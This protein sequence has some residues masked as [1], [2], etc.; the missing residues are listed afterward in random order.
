MSAQLIA[1]NLYRVILLT[2]MTL[3]IIMLVHNLVLYRQKL[4]SRFSMMLL[5]GTSVCVFE[6]LWDTFSFYPEL[7]PLI[8]ICTGAYTMSFLNFVGLFNR[9]FLDRFGISV[10]KKWVTWLIYDLPNAIMLILCITTPWT[11][12]F[13]YVDP[14]GTVQYMPLSTLYYVLLWTYNLTALGLAVHYMLSKKK[15]DASLAKTARSL[16]IFGC[17]LTVFDLI[18]IWILGGTYSDYLVSSLAVSV[19][20]VYLTANINVNALMESRSQFEAV[21]A[22]LR[23]AATIQSEALP[24]PAPE[25]PDHPEINL[26]CSMDTAKEVG[27]DFYDYFSIDADHICFL[28]ADV[29]GKGTAAALFMMKAKTTIKDYALTNSSTAEIFTAV[30]PRL[31]ENNDTGMFATAWI[32]ILDTRTMV[33]QYTNAGHNYPVLQRKGEASAFLKAKHGLFLAGMDDTEYHFSELQMM[34]GDRLLLYTDGIP[35]ARNSE[36]KFYGDERLLEVME[37][38]VNTSGDELIANITN[39]VNAF[40]QD[41]PQF[42]DMTMLVVTIKGGDE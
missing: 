17:I 42:D 31:R 9:Y 26:R 7:S 24:P 13:Y 1:D 10:H 29:S 38:S 11:H 12:L 15:K 34:P 25:F 2:S 5:C 23:V 19:S 33:L 16:I 37:K 40:V 21:E 18:Q 14:A 22:D 36:K 27:G 28:I 3:L 41:A 30:N 20:L 39:D 4:S 6:F 8:Y 32:G 35:E